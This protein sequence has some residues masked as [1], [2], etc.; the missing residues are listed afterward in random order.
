MYGPPSPGEH[1]KQTSSMTGR[2]ESLLWINTRR[3]PQIAWGR[4]G[5]ALRLGSHD[6]HSHKTPPTPNTTPY[7]EPQTD[8]V[9]EF[10]SRQS[11]GLQNNTYVPASQ[12]LMSE[13]QCC[14]CCVS[15][16]ICS[17]TCSDVGA[18]RLGGIYGRIVLSAFHR[19]KNHLLPRRA[20]VVP[21]P[22]R[23]AIQRVK[24]DCR[25]CRPMRCSCDWRGCCDWEQRSL[26]LN[27]QVCL[28]CRWAYQRRLH[29]ASLCSPT[30]LGRALRHNQHLAFSSQGHTRANGDRHVCGCQ[31]GTGLIGEVDDHQHVNRIHHRCCQ[32]HL[33]NATNMYQAYP[34]S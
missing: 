15:A 8:R 6:P 28:R 9:P 5:S 4:W 23:H 18:L 13:L 26:W 22:A 34:T 32:Q 19:E 14:D 3:Q 20:L 29:L 11:N 31:W 10:E 12:R 1:Q 16:R 27:S 25:W 24:N 7:S 17:S 21:P 30:S 2:V 33:R